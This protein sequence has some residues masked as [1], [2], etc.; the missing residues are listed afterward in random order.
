M[1]IKKVLGTALAVTL[2]ATL[3]VAVSPATQAEAANASFFDPGNIISDA[4]FFDGGSMSAGSVQTFL[5]DRVTTCRSGYTCLKDYRQDTPTKSAIAGRCAEYSG[6][7]SESA[8]DIIAKVGVACGISQKAILVLLEKEQ[9]LV[10]DTWPTS[11]QYR[12][13]TGYG[14]PDTADCDANYYGFFNQV[15]AAALQFQ[16][17]AAN[18]TRWN[19]V[20]G[21]V[22]SVRFHPNSACGSSSVFIQNQATA[23]LYNYT[24]YQPNRAALSNL[25]GTGDSCSSYGNRNFWRMFSDW[26]GDPTTGTSLLR[27]NADATVYLISG[28]NKY[29]VTSASVL[30]ALAPLG[31]LGYVSQSYLDRYTTAHVVGRAIRSN[32][33]TIYFYDGGVKLPFSSCGQAVDYGASCASDGYVQL[34]DEQIN[35]FQSGPVLSSILGTVEGSR[36]H[37]K[38]GKK[39][40]ILDDES[41]SLAGISGSMNV[42][43]ENAVAALPLTMP[44]IR[45]GAFVRSRSTGSSYLLSGGLRYG[46]KAGSESSLGVT[47]RTFGSLVSASLLM[48]P[49]AP[50]NFGG[51]VRAAGTGPITAV[52]SEGRYE[53]AAG[54]V[55]ALTVPVPQAL[56]DSYESRGTVAAGSFVKSPNEA[57][58][59]VVMPS[60]I[61]PISG[62]DALLALTPDGNPVIT[63]VRSDVIAAFA[64]GP[65]ALRAGTLVRSPEDATVF[66]VNGVTSRIALS[67]FQFPTEAGFT[68]F[69]YSTQ[70]RIL[71]YPLSDKL[72]TF[73]LA[74]GTA[75]FV[76]AGGQVH[77]VDTTQEGLYP[78]VYVPMDQFT[79]GQLNR[80]S[81]ASNLI[82]TPDGSVYLLEAGKKRPISSMARLGEL[83]VNATWLEVKP[84]F[85][86]A[87]PTGANA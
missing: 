86:A 42:L 27:T 63:T 38:G 5:S 8:A 10:S 53:L 36:Y 66:F 2:A 24:P 50:A 14:C 73:G 9:G 61:R 15:Y 51:L 82:R 62:W 65:V 3:L 87:I 41:Q 19:H 45:D 64:V 40:E 71:A 59:Y 31:K 30:T 23:G 32:A 83:S 1:N 81:A 76:A 43:T 34:T 33:G 57:S 20:P 37:I 68:D 80:G 16:Y 6:R 4:V 69:T 28:Q 11:R 7:T 48:V 17:Y 84:A 39:A 52:S 72:M 56:I 29:P 75:K 78:F 44:I 13:A 46:V 22:N 12:S 18:P 77:A 55:K 26:F 49:A 79:C 58:V 47:P 70:E 25:Y 85:A 60:D 35:A 21:R 67:S 74:C 54:G